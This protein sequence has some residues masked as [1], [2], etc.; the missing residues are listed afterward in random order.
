M[1]EA[2]EQ[3]LEK[4]NP[5]SSADFENALKEILQ[6]IV[7]LGLDR[8]G[9]FEKAAFYGG[10]ALRIMHGLDRFSEELDFTLLEPDPKFKL[11]KY[12]SGLE[13][14]LKAFGFDVSL[15]R[16]DKS[17]VRKTESA[18]LKT[19]TQML[20]LAIQGTKIFADKVQKKQVLKFKFEVDVEPAISFD[21]E[22]KT[23]LLPSPYTV[24]T[25]TLPSLFGGKMHAALLRQWKNRTKGRDFY[26][27]Q[28][29]M[30]RNIPIKKSYLEDKM[31]ASGALNGPLTKKLLINLFEQRVDKI[32]WS[33]AKN[34]VIGFLK[35]KNQVHLWSSRFFKE[36]IQNIKLEI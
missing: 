2:V 15:E 7:L 19:N 21:T 4:Y 8:N 1:N 36:I 30:A 6:E 5:K 34:D 33:Q 35:D 26:D 24:K 29:Y 22:I 20:F 18:F 12:F 27:I 23:L 28:W 32:D 31:K 10:T 17:E 25:L 13:R 9:F 14:E 3:M 16:I 11:D